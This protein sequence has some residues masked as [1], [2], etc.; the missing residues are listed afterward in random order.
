MNTR[1]AMLHIAMTG[2]STMM[3]LNHSPEAIAQF[4]LLQPLKVMVALSHMIEDR[5]FPGTYAEA[6]FNVLAG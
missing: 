2:V 1:P 5:A 6:I 3:R 4:I